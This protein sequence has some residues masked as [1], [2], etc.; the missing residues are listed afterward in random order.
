MDLNQYLGKTIRI[1]FVDG[2]ILEGYCNTF[3]GKLDTEEELYDEA[4]IA[5]DKYKYISFNENAVASI[6]VID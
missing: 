4:T 1:T 3:T 5:T 2:Q 6:E